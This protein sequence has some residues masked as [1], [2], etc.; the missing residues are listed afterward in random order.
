MRHGPVRHWRPLAAILLAAAAIAA[1]PVIGFTSVFG[2]MVS[3]DQNVGW[4][5]DGADASTFWDSQMI[6]LPGVSLTA[7]HCHG[8]MRYD[9]QLGA[10]GPDHHN[11]CYAAMNKY[12]TNGG[13]SS[14]I[15]TYM[16]LLGNQALYRISTNDQPWRYCIGPQITALPSAGPVPVPC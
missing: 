2:T 6:D 10:T 14:E 1:L 3:L 13:G 16:T 12:N 7:V 11:P 9:V 15:D 8:K 4:S 5:S